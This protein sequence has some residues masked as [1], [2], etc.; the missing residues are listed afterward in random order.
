MRYRSHVLHTLLKGFV[1]RSG[2]R[3]GGREG[4]RERG[5]EGE[6]EGGREGGERERGRDIYIWREEGRRKGRREGEREGGRER[7]REG[8]RGE[9][10]REG[11]IYTYG[12]RR[13]GRKERGRER[14]REGGR[15]GER[16]GGRHVMNLT[17][18]PSCS[19][20]C[21]RGHE[22]LQATLPS[23]FEHVLLVRPSPVQALLYD[24]NMSQMQ[25]GGTS[26][27][28][29]PLRAFAVCS[30]VGGRVR[31]GGGELGEC[32]CVGGGGELG[33]WGEGEGES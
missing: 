32:V 21:R 14:G 27:T 6:R 4:E 17:L 19:P 11:G 29:G 18:P 23:K 20:S 10:G 2:G 24:Y 5:R 12:G 1:L 7:G 26:T 13:E 25:Q 3:E 15:E 9:R 28:A 16:E 31:G 22:I 33:E 8:G 30:K